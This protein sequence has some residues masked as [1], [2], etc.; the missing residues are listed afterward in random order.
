MFSGCTPMNLNG[1][2]PDEIMN[3]LRE[4]EEKKPEGQKPKG[5]EEKKEEKE[6]KDLMPPDITGAR[7]I[8][9]G[10]GRKPNYSADLI[11]TDDK[12]P[13]VKMVIDDSRV[14]LN[15]PGTYPVIYRATDAAGN[16]REVEIKVTVK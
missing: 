16:V 5:E 14:N 8:T 4:K 7:D 15:E 1:E 12:D 10:V 11:V 3:A 9:I 2:N 13:N 6:D